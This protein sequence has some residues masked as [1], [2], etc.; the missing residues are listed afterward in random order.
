MSVKSYKYHG[1][2]AIAV[3]A[4]LIFTTAFAV[5]SVSASAGDRPF[6]GTM[7]NNDQVVSFTPGVWDGEFQIRVGV[8]ISGEIHATHLGKGEVDGFAVINFL[9]YLAG[10]CSH[11]IDGTIDFVAANGDEINMEMTV[12][13]LC[14]D[15]GLFTGEYEVTG[16][17]GRFASAEGTIEVTGM[18]I[19]G[20]PSVN[21]LSGVIVY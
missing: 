18:P 11:L 21:T 3:F 12:N 17:S 20:Q 13:Q 15:T 1:L 14:A 4:V 6:K 19:Q 2:T 9:P 16:G 10:G 8:D 5:T 7:V